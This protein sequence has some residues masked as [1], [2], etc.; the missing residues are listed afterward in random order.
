MG[1]PNTKKLR[2]DNFVEYKND[3]IISQVNSQLDKEACEKEKQ[4]F[5][6]VSKHNKE[7]KDRELLE[8]SLFE[9]F[10]CVL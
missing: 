1:N 4:N 3:L 8:N 10:F 5:K 9:H 7:L 6:L 2:I